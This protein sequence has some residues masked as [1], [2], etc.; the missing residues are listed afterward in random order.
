L[1]ATYEI[2]VQFLET[3]PEPVVVGV[4][5]KIVRITVACSTVPLGHDHAGLVHDYP[6][7]AR[8]LGSRLAVYT[9]CLFI[10]RAIFVG[11]LWDDHAHILERVFIFTIVAGLSL[12]V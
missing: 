5:V 4:H 7:P 9:A 10:S 12:A 2:L 3:P 6:F 11:P 1:E 8:M